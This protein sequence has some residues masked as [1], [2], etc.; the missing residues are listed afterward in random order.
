MKIFLSEEEIKTCIDFS[1][2]SAKTQQAIEFGQ[3]DTAKRSISEIA[4]DSVIGKMAEIAFAKFLKEK[5]GIIVSLDFNIYPIYQGDNADVIIF[6][7]SIDIKASRPGAEWLLVEC[8]MV[9]SK[10]C[11]NISYSQLL[12][13]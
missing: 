7:T 8:N 1:I 12:I 4:R 13:G 3:R 6:G 10:K 5:F 9:N 2:S 11:C